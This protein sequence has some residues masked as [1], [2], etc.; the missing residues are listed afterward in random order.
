MMRVSGPLD[1]RTS[2]N[3]PTAVKRPSAMATAQ[4]AGHARSSVVNLP[5]VR[6]SSGSICIT[7]G[8]GVGSGVVVGPGRLRGFADRQCPEHVWCTFALQPTGADR[9]GREQA[10]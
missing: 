8:L 9:L 10:F 1:A 2:E 5:L 7:P 3:S 6:I 4:A